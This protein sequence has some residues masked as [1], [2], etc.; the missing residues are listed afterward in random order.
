[1]EVELRGQLEKY[2][3]AEGDFRATI[4]EQ[5]SIIA[6]LNSHIAELEAKLAEYVE[7]EASLRLEIEGLNGNNWE[8]RIKQLTVDIEGKEISHKTSISEL[9]SIIYELR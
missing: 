2:E 6:E 4:E 3:L 5:E 7:L 9:E 1:M 8:G